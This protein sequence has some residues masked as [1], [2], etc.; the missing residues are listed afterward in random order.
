MS[1]EESENK[2]AGLECL[3]DATLKR[4]IDDIEEEWSGEAR[5]KAFFELAS[6]GE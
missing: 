5:E 6:R 3:S 4:I 1:N 2:P